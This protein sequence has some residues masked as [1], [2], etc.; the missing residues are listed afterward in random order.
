MLYTFECFPVWEMGAILQESFAKDMRAW[1]PHL[2]VAAQYKICNLGDVNRRRSH[3]A[4]RQHA[5]CSEVAPTVTLLLLLPYIC[6]KEQET[7]LLQVW[8]GVCQV[9]GQR[10]EGQT[11]LH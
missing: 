11:A 10:R 7:Q 6:P 9:P 5:A 4:A 3:H 1:D 8:I 2:F